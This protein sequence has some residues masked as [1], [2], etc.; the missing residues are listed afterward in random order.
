[1]KVFFLKFVLCA[2]FIV[3]GVF[4]AHALDG[5]AVIVNPDVA[6]DHLSA[7]KLR[8]IYTARTKYWSDGQAIIIVVLPDTTD[9]AL[10]QVSGMDGSQFRTFWQRLAFSGRGSEPEKADSTADLVAFV[11]ATKGAIA[12][13]P[14]D[15]VLNGVKRIDIK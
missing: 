5:V 4:R 15:A 7:D 11:A 12:I 3:A 8:D 14:A 6:T 2:T 1:M 10:Q 13:V 9:A